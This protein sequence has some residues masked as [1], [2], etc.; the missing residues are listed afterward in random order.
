MITASFAHANWGHIIFNL[1]FFVAFAATV[2]VL[3]GGLAY[4]TFIV[5]NSVL[6]GVV[7]SVAAFGEH[8][9]TLGLSG[10]VMGMIG[11]YSYLLPRGKIRCYYWIIILFGSIALPAWM[12]A[13]WYIG[14]DV[15]Q[16]FTHDDHGVVNVLAHVTGG[17]GGYLFGMMFLKKKKRA[18]EEL[19]QVLDKR[20][21]RPGPP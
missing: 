14:G 21:L 11:L 16:L 13:L 5:A 17:I 4:T 15:Y 12:L 18:A 3:I 10:I 1:I 20:S 9:W 7:G 8:Y 6:I 2:E 19:Q